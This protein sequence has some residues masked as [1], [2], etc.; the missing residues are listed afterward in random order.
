M[1]LERFFLVIL[2]RPDVRPDLEEA[3]V[4]RLQQAHLD[5]LLGL[6]E[7]GV[8]ALN[9]PL[10]DQPDPTLRG[11]S[12]YRTS[13]AEQARAFAEADPMVQAGWFVF[14]LMTF[15]SR[16]GELVRTGTPITLGD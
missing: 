5:Y 11:L 1:E 12:F 13:T 3:E 2:K 15:L 10:L 9:G 6:R 4:D 7:Q 8:L 16:P 14:D